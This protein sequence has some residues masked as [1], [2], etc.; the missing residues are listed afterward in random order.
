MESGRGFIYHGWD[1]NSLCNLSHTFEPPTSISQVLDYNH[2]AQI[3]DLIF[4]SHAFKLT[5]FSGFSLYSQEAFNVVLFLFICHLGIYWCFH[6]MVPCGSRS[7]TQMSLFSVFSTMVIKI[8][9]INQF[10]G[11][12]L[13][14]LSHLTSPLLPWLILWATCS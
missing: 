3:F 12:C 9:W 10:G 2:V 8:L 1:L 14:L 13:S 11:K 7:T 4:F 5:F 6:A